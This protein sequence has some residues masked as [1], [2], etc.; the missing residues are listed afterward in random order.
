MASNFGGTRNGMVMHWPQGIKAKGEI[1]SQFHHV[2]DMAPTILEAA[3]LPEPK[4]VNG[5]PQMPIEGV[6]MAYSFDDAGRARIG[7][8][9]STSRCS[10]IAPST[11]TAGLP[12]PSTR[13]RGR[14]RCARPLTEDVWELYDVRSDFS[15]ARNLAA[16]KPDEAGGDAGLFM[17]EAEKYNVL[18]I[19]DRLLERLNAAAVG[20]PDIMGGRTSLTLAEGMT[21]MS[22]N[23]F[24]N[25]KNRS[26]TITA[27]LEMPASGGNGT[28][29]AQG[30][31]FGGWS[32]YVKDG[33]PAYDYN[34]LGLER[35]SVKS[36]HKLAP[37]KST[38]KLD[39]AYDGGG[40]GQ[41]RPGDALR[42]R[43]EGRR[44]THRAHAARHLLGR[45][46]G[47]RRHRLRRRPWSRRSARSGSRASR[48]AFRRSSCSC[49][50]CGW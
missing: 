37:G 9:R 29:I 1:R 2:I 17:K 36:S 20:R 40:A 35:F 49:A 12:A 16:E 5:T 25:I 41:G 11:T 14:R 7:T 26:M 34:F 46:D 19:D 15:L 21:G 45:R 4:V 50:R 27:E 38:V 23:T 18:P 31:R 39:F 44:G 6:S 28:V 22:E 43:R 24:L 48:V 13:R 42:Q 8:S 30:G 3:K 32:L 33:V 10:A 47:G